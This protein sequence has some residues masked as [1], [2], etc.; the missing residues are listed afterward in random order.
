MPS[1]FA[2]QI[3]G[4]LLDEMWLSPLAVPP[5]GGI[6][7]DIVHLEIS[8]KRASLQSPNMSY[9]LLFPAPLLSCDIYLTIREGI[10]KE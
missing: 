1:L 9:P 8:D 4:M 7:H 10:Q 2:Y 6:L 5:S 3:A